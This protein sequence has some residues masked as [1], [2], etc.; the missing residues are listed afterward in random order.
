[1]ERSLRGA[2]FLHGTKEVAE[3]R[4]YHPYH[5]RFLH[6]VRASWGLLFFLKCR[7]PSATLTCMLDACTFLRSMFC[8]WLCAQDQF[9]GEAGAHASNHLCAV[10]LM[11]VVPTALG[12]MFSHPLYIPSA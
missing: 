4:E 2:I 12:G 7:A 11:A 1:M 5:Q 8:R 3:N 10:P 6:R 9:P